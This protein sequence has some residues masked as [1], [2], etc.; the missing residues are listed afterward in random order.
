MSETLRRVA[1]QTSLEQKVEIVK[2]LKPS[3][4]EEDRPF[5]NWDFMKQEL[6]AK[7]KDALNRLERGEY[8]YCM[9]CGGEVDPARLMSMFMAIR[10]A[11]C[12]ETHHRVS[13]PARRPDQFLFFS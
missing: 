10:C 12:Q 11:D 6:L 3:N 13:I 2:G 1:L 5:S 8:G 7:L 9:D 4:P